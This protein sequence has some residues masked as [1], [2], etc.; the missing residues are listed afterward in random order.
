MA[1]CSF[2]LCWTRRTQHR[3]KNEKYKKQQKTISNTYLPK[4]KSV[5]HLSVCVFLA[6]AFRS[7]AIWATSFAHGPQVKSIV[8][9]SYL[10]FNIFLRAK[11]TQHKKKNIFSLYNVKRV[12]FSLPF[13]PI[14]FHHPSCG[15]KHPKFLQI[16]VYT[17]IMCSKHSMLTAM[18]P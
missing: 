2:T 18:V 8:H 1:V 12:F 15:I 14:F 11:K 10:S 9:V 3:K 17:L 16:Q 6:M 4:E 7:V 13:F 5:S